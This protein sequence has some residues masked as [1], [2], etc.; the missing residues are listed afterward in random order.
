MENIT[1][2]IDLIAEQL[3]RIR[4]PVLRQEFSFIPAHKEI[5]DRVSSLVLAG[6]KQPALVLHHPFEPLL[7]DAAVNTGLMDLS[8]CKA[9]LYILSQIHDD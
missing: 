4:R 6:E 1:T 7:L 9:I 8:D 3:Q 5:A 2:L